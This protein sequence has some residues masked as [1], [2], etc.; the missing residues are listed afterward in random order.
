MSSQDESKKAQRKLS[1]LP[2]RIQTMIIVIFTA[3]SLVSISLLGISLLRMFTERMEQSTEEAMEQLIR[4][5]G[6]EVENDLHDM[7]SLSD[8]LYYTVI[9]DKDFAVDSISTEMNLLYEENQE[10]VVSIALYQKNGNLIGAVPN[11]TEKLTVNAEDQMWF[12]AALGKVENLHFSTPHVQN[13]FRS[14]TMEYSWVI[15]VSRAVDLTLDGRQSTGV[16]LV[17]MNYSSLEQML[18]DVNEETSGTYL[19]LVHPNGNLIYH[20]EK[21]LIDAGIKSENYETAAEYTD[22]IH[23][24]E[25]EGQKRIVIVDTISYTGWKLVGVIPMS[26]FNLSI[27]K[28]RAYVVLF[29]ALMML[30]ALIM[31]QYFARRISD[32]IVRLND[33][34][35]NIET[36]FTLDDSVFEGG[37]EEVENLGRSIQ[38]YLSE[39]RR[40]MDHI[41]TEQESKRK[42]ELDALQSQINPHFLYNTLDSIVWMIEGGRQQEAVTMI[43]DLA[44]FF[45]L[46]L[47]KGKTIISVKDELSHAK[48]YMNI[49]KVRYKNAFEVEF[50]SEGDVEDY[51]IVKLVVQPILENALYHGMKDVEEDGKI[52]VHA[53]RDADD[54][55][56]EVSDNGYGMSEEEAAGLLTGEE[57]EFSTK[58][59]SGVGVLN[60]HR[61]IQLRF[62]EQYGLSVASELD[63]GTTVTIHIPAVPF[64]KENQERLEEGLK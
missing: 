37:S 51:C 14:S 25:F 28:T 35:Q 54:I 13:L 44:K 8:T 61:R 7:R 64:T 5:V 24:E 55:Y 45:R 40:L 2:R 49:Q 38:A 6:M 56:I 59:G 52:R 15:S 39:I 31:N 18:D 30:G 58:K 23:E 26:T 12:L 19:Y 32:P 22:G 53:W 29:A 62:G 48:T 63:E 21:D 60:V 34:I 41:V 9:K 46:S 27:Q 50:D 36:G 3:V 11:S 1:L 42:S 43:T 20:P 47:S 17:D 4:Q 33:A 10:D 16:L 57:K